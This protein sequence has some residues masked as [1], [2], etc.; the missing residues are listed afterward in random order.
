MA[1]NNQKIGEMFKFLRDN[2]DRPI[3]LKAQFK[4][5]PD[6][7]DWEGLAY[8]IQDLDLIKGS[9]NEKNIV[10]DK[11]PQSD[12]EV[13][14]WVMNNYPDKINPKKIDI[15]QKGVAGLLAKTKPELLNWDSYTVDTYVKAMQGLRIAK[16]LID[17]ENKLDYNDLPTMKFMSQKAPELVDKTK[18]TDE[19]IAS[20]F[21]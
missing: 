9:S 16:D 14:R 19:K 15:N 7:I 17:W 1:D 5:T 12:F 3:P 2:E 10:W 8:D 4:F 11:V 21:S 18:I 20:L 13:L 6:V